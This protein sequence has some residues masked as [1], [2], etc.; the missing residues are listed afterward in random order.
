MTWWRWRIVW[1]RRRP[2][3]KASEVVKVYAQIKLLWPPRLVDPFSD[4]AAVMV[5][6]AMPP[7]VT[8][9]HALAVVEEFFRRGSPFPPSWPEIAKR[10]TERASGIEDDPD[11]IVNTWL[12]EV[13]EAVHRV[14]SYRTPEWSDPIIGAAV[15]QAAGSWVDWCHTPTGGAGADGEPYV[16]NLAPERDERFRRLVKAMLRHRAQTGESLPAIVGGARMALPSPVASDDDEF[17]QQW[18]AERPAGELPPGSP[19]KVPDLSMDRKA[20]S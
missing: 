2:L 19:F 9:E 8:V 7:E 3:V 13:T 14:G 16:R 18:V 5:A 6:A 10:W 1:K 4:D 12:R 15:E 17:V 20:D 11:V